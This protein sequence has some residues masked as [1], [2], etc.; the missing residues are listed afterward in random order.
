M[1]C[2]REDQTREQHA[3]GQQA[4]ACTVE[5]TQPP[6]GRIEARTRQMP[7]EQL[8]GEQRLRHAGAGHRI[9]EAGGI[10]EQHEARRNAAP[11]PTRER[12]LAG[13]SADLI[14]AAQ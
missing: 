4:L 5:L 10:A 12:A 2:Q 1:A 11:R 8:G 9:D 13:D 7:S 3:V 14:G 6:V